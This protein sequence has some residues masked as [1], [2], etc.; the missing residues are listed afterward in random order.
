MKEMAY[1]PHR[2]FNI[3]AHGEYNGFPYWV[4]S[5][6]TH[7]CA[8]VDVTAIK[9]AL[10]PETVECHGGVTFDEDRLRN[11]WDE[12]FDG[13]KDG[14]RRFIGWDYA[15]SG[16]YFGGPSELFPQECDHRWRTE[17]IV[18]E[19]KEVIESLSHKETP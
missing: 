19:I 16:D 17:E 1:Q 9:D 14:E 13:F 7:P 11:V 10:D 2:C 4:V 5:R 3:L 8:Y 18:A 15:H 12:A 6:G